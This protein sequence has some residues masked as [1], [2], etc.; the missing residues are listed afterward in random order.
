MRKSL[1]RKAASLLFLLGLVA[2]ASA[3]TK[4][5]EH[6]VYAGVG[7]ANTMEDGD[8]QTTAFHVG[9]G[10]NYY[11]SPQWSVMPGVS[12][13]VKTWLGEPKD[14]GESYNAV[15]FDVPLLVQY[16]FGGNKREGVVVECG[17]VLSFLTDG[18][19]YFYD[20]D[21]W[22]PVNGKEEYKKFDLGIRPAVYYETGHWRFGVQSH[23]GLLDTKCKY[24]PYVTDR[25]HAFDVVATVNFHW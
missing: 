2:S 17:P 14:G 13:R 4:H 22:H 8:E 10:L 15:Y 16:H 1:Y 12:L 18:D 9:Y 23:I 6:N 21:P 25:Y 5:W 20:A 24:P 19:T 7:I 11:I 3:Q